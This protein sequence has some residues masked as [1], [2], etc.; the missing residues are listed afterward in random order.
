MLQGP[1][2]ASATPT[3]QVTSPSVDFP[4]LSPGFRGLVTSVAEVQEVK[5]ADCG[6]KAHQLMVSE[7]Q[8]C[9][10]Q[11]EYSISNSGKKIGK[12]QKGNV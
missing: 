3:G 8:L 11:D 5:S 1:L 7:L 2:H 9:A 4:T 10:N 12:T 6:N